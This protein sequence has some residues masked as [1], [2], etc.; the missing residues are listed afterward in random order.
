MD[1]EKNGFLHGELTKKAIG[2]F[3]EVYNEL[4]HGFLE[5]VYVKSLLCALQDA[6][7]RAE[8]EK[9]LE[10]WFRTHLVGEFRTD[11][12]LEGSVIVEVKAARCL[13]PIH[14]AQLLNYLRASTAEVGL[15]FNFGPKAG[16][17]RFIFPNSKKK[18]SS[19]R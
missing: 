3:F 6:G 13:D 2:V 5:S 11:L 14:E 8:S 7:I 9:P 16:F 17:K 19:S 4:G 15:L 18:L 1:Q 10:V 12:L